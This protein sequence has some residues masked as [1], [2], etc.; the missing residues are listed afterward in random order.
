MSEIQVGQI[1]STD[2]S[3]AIT[4]S[5]GNTTVANNLTVTGGFVPSTQIGGRRNL[6]ING[7]MQVW[8]R[9]TSSTAVGGSREAN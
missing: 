3:T 8:Q 9:G 6:I 1:N 4:T 2:G 5:S 7:A